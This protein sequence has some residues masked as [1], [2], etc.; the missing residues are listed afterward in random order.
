MSV[1]KTPGYRLTVWSCRFGSMIMSIASCYTPLLFLF[2]RDRYDFTYTQLGALVLV[3]FTTQIATDLLFS[4]AA[5]RYGFRPFV[6]LGQFLCAAGFLAFAMT[7]FLLR[8]FEYA[9][10][11]I[12]TAIFSVGAGL[13]ELLL[14]PILDALPSDDPERDMSMM[15]SFYAWGSVLTIVLSTVLLRVLGMESWP[16][17]LCSWAV[18]P[19]I[20]GCMFLKAPLRQKVAEDDRMPTRKLLRE[21]A[22]LLGFFAILC[23]GASELSMSQWT[24]SFVER[25][26]KLPKLW[27]DII[28]MAGF[29]ALMAVGRTLHG[30][31][32]KRLNLRAVLIFGSLGAFLCYL[33]ASLSGS[34]TVGMLACCMTGLFVSLLWPATL[35]MT[36]AALPLAGATMFA[37]MAAG[38]DIGCSAA[39]WLT[40]VITDL[41]AANVTVAGL[42]PDELGLRAGL[43]IAAVFPLG[44]LVCQL[45]LRR[46][47]RTRGEQT[48]LL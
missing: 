39:P 29:S 1:E 20:C 38:G 2:L 17:I 31:L 13:Q 12:S 34:G 32:G 16:W 40:G 44:S 43:L 35:S 46:L 33:A 47:D 4:R 18:L 42:T 5:D 11:V 48:Y 26:L 24:S 10:F 36:S 19:V 30:M 22:F 25:A 15:H 23:G 3:N 45:L 28:G 8:G 14:S 6:V 21:P 9:G 41:V 27:G 7:P 37:F